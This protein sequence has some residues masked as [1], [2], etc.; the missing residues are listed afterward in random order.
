MD[1]TVSTLAPD[2]TAAA[3]GHHQAEPRVRFGPGRTQTVPLEWAAIM[4][5][6]LKAQNPG[7]FGKLL[8]QAASEAE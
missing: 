6:L 1:T 5:T 3:N 7:L 2:L 8:S 4:L